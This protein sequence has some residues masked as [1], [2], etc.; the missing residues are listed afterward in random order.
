MRGCNLNLLMHTD[1]GY[2]SALNVMRTVVK[3]KHVR[4]W[5]SVKKHGIGISRNRYSK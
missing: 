3:L 4:T 1:H 2:G 5:K